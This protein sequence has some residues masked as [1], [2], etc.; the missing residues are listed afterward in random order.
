[1]AYEFFAF[2]N[3]KNIDPQDLKPIFVHTSRRVH[4]DSETD[5]PLP[6]RN[7]TI[8]SRE[9]SDGFGRLLQT[10]S[11]A[12]DTIF[13]DAI[14][15]TD[16][17]PADQNDQADTGRD[18]AGRRR[19]P[20]EPANVVVNGWQF[21]DNKGR[22]VQKYEPFFSTGYEYAAPSESQFGQKV[23][24]F[25]DPRGHL[26]R[27]VNPDGSEQRVIFGVP[28]TIA[29][30]DVSNPDG[31]EPT[32]WE[33]YTYDANDNAGRTAPIASASYRHHWNT[34]GSIVIDALAGC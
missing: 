2:L 21:Y 12:E 34:P 33:A 30:P 6:E 17:V 18:V 13:G 29:Q 25:Y 24:M 11:Q 8:E 1:M 32:P 28:G 10:R 14:F 9:Y 7:E 22:I 27:S 20:A 5:I 16:V 19:G 23:E 4:H 15:G 3:S 31:Y 26:I